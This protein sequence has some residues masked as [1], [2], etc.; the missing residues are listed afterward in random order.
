MPPMPSSLFIF[1]IRKTTSVLPVDQATL[2]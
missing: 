2:Q 1:W